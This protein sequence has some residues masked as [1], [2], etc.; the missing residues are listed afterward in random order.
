VQGLDVG[1]PA[2]LTAPFEGVLSEHGNHGSVLIEANDAIGQGARISGRYK[3]TTLSILQKVRD[4]TDTA[5][6]HRSCTGHCLK[7]HRGKW[8]VQGRH[9]DRMA[10]KVMVGQDV[11]RARTDQSHN[12]SET[13]SLNPLIKI[14]N[15]AGGA[16]GDQLKL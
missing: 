5:G 3:Q 11:A 4:P 6:Q 15:L 13:E 9:D 8:I 10:A 1:L 7:D 14:L 12:V 16:M 2:E